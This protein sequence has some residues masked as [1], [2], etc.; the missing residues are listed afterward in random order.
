MGAKLDMQ[1][2]GRLEKSILITSTGVSTRIEGVKLSDEDIGKMMR[3]FSVQK[4]SDCDK[5]EVKGYF[6]LFENVC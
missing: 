4:F 1:V 6:E 2:L 5:Q 3:R